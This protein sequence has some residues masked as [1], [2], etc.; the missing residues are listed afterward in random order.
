MM[1]TALAFGEAG[2]PIIPVRLS[3]DGER[4]RKQPM[5]TWDQATSN[6]VTIEWWW[7]KWPDALPGIPLARVNWAVVDADRREGVDGVAQVTDLGP[8]GPHSRIATPSG[9]LHLVFAQ[10]PKPITGR[11]KWCEGVEVLGEGCLLTCYDLEELKFPHVAPRAVLPE[12]FWRPRDDVGTK[13]DPDN[14]RSAPAPDVPAPD[15]PAPDVA[16]V[17]DLTAALRKID[18]RDY[19]GEHD[20][21]LALMSACQAVGI[22][23]EDFVAWSVGDPQYAHDGHLI[24][25][26][27]RSLKPRHGG[28]L[29][30]AL[31]ERGVKVSPVIVRDPL[32]ERQGERPTPTRNW[33][34]RLECTCNALEQNPTEPMLFW[35][36][37]IF[38]EVMAECKRPTPSVAATLLEQSAKTCGLWKT[39]GKDGVRRTIAN[40]LRHVEEKMLAGTEN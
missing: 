9:G 18:P 22:E 6:E 31:A 20:A 17:P 10:P 27:W 1:L 2:F 24:R 3:H 40:G 35:A 30:A 16:L 15:V 21:W 37:C 19:R 32:R 26:K 36:A 7:R 29:Y 13:R 28:V 33:R 23:R 8:L 38:A 39:L 12:M 25:R 14:K 4:W 5:T 11:F 34:S